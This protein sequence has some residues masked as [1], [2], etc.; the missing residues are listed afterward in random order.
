MVQLEVCRTG[1]KEIRALTSISAT[2]MWLS[3]TLLTLSGCAPSN[4]IPPELLDR[5][6]FEIQ[7]DALKKN[8]DL[9]RGKMVILG[10]EIIEMR[11]LTTGTQVEI[12]H[13]P[14]DQNAVPLPLGISSGRFLALDST[15]LD[16]RVFQAGRLVTVIGEVK[17]NATIVINGI[18]TTYPLLQNRYIQVNGSPHG[19]SDSQLLIIPNPF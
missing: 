19:D 14:L 5:I 7:F 18:E 4:R 10:G 11:N 1:R 17:G 6:D 13:K 9:Y 16:P 15:I 8:T 3:M 2:I 12:L